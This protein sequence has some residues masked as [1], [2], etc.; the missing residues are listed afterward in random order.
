MGFEPGTFKRKQS[1]NASLSYPLDLHENYNR[2]ISAN[3]LT[4]TA[5]C[6]VWNETIRF[7]SHIFV[8]IPAH[9]FSWNGRLLKVQKH[10]NKQNFAIT[11]S[12][13]QNIVYSQAS[14]FLFIFLPFLKS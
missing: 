13:C 7:H 8:S 12:L 4:R 3:I 5:F 10:D 6:T 1:H 11:V 2:A 14:I 9:P